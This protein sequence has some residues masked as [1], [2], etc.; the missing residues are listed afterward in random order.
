MFEKNE[1]THQSLVCGNE[2]WRLERRTFSGLRSLKLGIFKEKIS[3][4]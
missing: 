4:E 3:A 2:S 1:G